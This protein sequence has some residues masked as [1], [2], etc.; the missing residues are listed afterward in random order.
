MSKITKTCAVKN[1]K[2]SERLKE[3]VKMFKITQDFQKFKPWKQELKIAENVEFRGVK[4][5]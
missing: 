4:S 5:Y 2:Y 1:C 3:N